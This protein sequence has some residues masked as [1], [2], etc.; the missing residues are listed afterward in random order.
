HPDWRIAV[1][2]CAAAIPSGPIDDPVFDAFLSEVLA[3]L[4]TVVA[5]GGVDAVYLS[6]H[7]EAMTVN[8]PRPDLDLVEAVRSRLPRTPLAATFDMHAN[9][10]PRL[11]S[12]LAVAG[13]YRT[14]PHVDMR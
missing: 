1:S 11:G 12:L 3:D 13:G 7:G 2:R 5:A 4:D 6:L 8:R 14:H 9:M 10:H